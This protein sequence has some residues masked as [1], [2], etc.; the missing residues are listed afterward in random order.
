MFNSVDF[1]KMPKYDEFKW[2]FERS[3]GHWNVIDK[4]TGQ[5]V[6]QYSHGVITAGPPV[7]M[8]DSD[9]TVRKDFAKFELRPEY[10]VGEIF[11]TSSI[12]CVEAISIYESLLLGIVFI[13]AQRAGQNPDSAFDKFNKSCLTWL[14]N[15]DM[16]TAPAST[17]YHDAFHAGLLYHS[18]KVYNRSM[19]LLHVS[20][21][22]SIS[23][24]SAALVALTHDWCKI[25]LYE[26]YQKNVKNEKTGK[27]EQVLAYKY[28]QKGI[29][30]GH[31]VSSMYLA[32]RCFRLNQDEALAIRWHMGW[33]R[34]AEA[35]MN[36][37]QMANE[38]WPL[39]H[40]IQFA[41]QLSITNYANIGCTQDTVD[42]HPKED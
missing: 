34:V 25:G 11:D 22:N 8:T 2:W 29:P 37:L 5:R 1:E 3:D 18:I 15:T 12:S 6:Y 32:S 38:C 26:S 7:D 24:D 39:V 13:R 4:A 28:N 42:E 31:G 33:C 41:D 20:G 21:F 9:D 23:I 35:D 30:L 10:L 16:Y 14:R 27:W 17:Q 40:L 19:E 36:E